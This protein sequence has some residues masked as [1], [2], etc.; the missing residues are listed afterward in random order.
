MLKEII[1]K[2]FKS[3]ETTHIELETYMTI[4]TGENNSGKTSLLES[5]MIFQEC[6][7]TSIF[8]IQKK[9]I[10]KVKEGILSVGQYDFA[11]KN[12][13]SFHSVRSTDKKELFFKDSNTFSIEVIFEIDERNLSVCFEV[14]R[15][16][17]EGIYNIKPIITND[18]LILLN[19]FEPL[20]FLYII[21]TQPIST[22]SSNEVYL[23]PKNLQSNIEHNNSRNI[24]RNRLLDISKDYALFSQ[25][26]TQ[27]EYILGY[28]FVFD[29]RFNL[30]EDIYIDIRFKAKD[31]KY[32]QDIA[33]L[34]SGTLQIIEV[35]IG[36]NIDNDAS[37][38]I[39]LLDEPDSHMH[40]SLQKRLITKLR[41]IS[42]N[43]IQIFITTH[44]EQI[45]SNSI[46]G[47]VIHLYQSNTT[48]TVKPISINYKYGR[49]TGMIENISKSKVY[50]TLGVSSTIMEL[51]EAV[52]SDR[53]VLVEGKSDA[54]FIKVLQQNKEN[55]IPASNNTSSVKF[56]SIN[57]IDDLPNKL[58][59]W[60]SILENIKNE[61]DIWSKS[62]L[63]LDMDSLTFDESNILKK[64]IEKEYNIKVFFWK[65]YTI[66]SLILNDFKC[67]SKVF[68]KLYECNSDD[69][70]Q[71]LN[72]L[73]N[74]ID[75]EKFT[76]RITGQRKSRGDV[77]YNTFNDTSLKLFDGDKYS[78]YLKFIEENTNKLKLLYSK[79]EIKELFAILFSKFNIDEN[80]DEN[81]LTIKFFENSTGECLGSDINSLLGEI[82]G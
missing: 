25:L 29:I 78:N 39:V 59:Y 38:K 61:K 16:K 67:F 12:I 82:Y 74:N 19:T 47:E 45:I 1:L 17:V 18:N 58:K 51:L 70:Y 36:L 62:I 66:E 71:E 46:F 21:N 7:H 40:R 73:N 23:S 52:E 57:G 24:I 76:H 11:G 56:W 55:Y 69:V 26:T 68:S 30:N 28:K 75:I 4:I 5:L 64:H 6:Y 79:D 60:K 65:A 43:K 53:V 34:G 81:I 35:L 13:S 14:S 3:H 15:G 32:F 44:N 80:I 2:N 42:K 22:I 72:K 20:N 33:L 9:T 48:M 41:E 10:K 49:Q 50:E 27:I 54:E 63:V 37:E 31:D 77:Y 8:E